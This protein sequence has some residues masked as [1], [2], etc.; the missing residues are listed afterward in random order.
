MKLLAWPERLEIRHRF[1]QATWMHTGHAHVG[2]EVDVE[3]GEV[4]PG[5][6]TGAEP[7]AGVGAAEPESG[8]GAADPEAAEV[9]AAELETETEPG[10]DVGVEPG[11]GAGAAGPGAAGVGAAETGSGV[12]VEPG[13]G[14][15]PE[16]DGV[17]PE[18]GVG[19][20]PETTR[21]VAL[22]F[23]EPN[24]ND[25]ACSVSKI[26]VRGEPLK[27]CPDQPVQTV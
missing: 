26:C 8:A 5:V 15:E 16:I 14:T 7:G 17:E 4:E 22:S 20:E 19:V 9:G 1:F 10:I 25:Q 18:A 6:D 3:A 24:Q 2:V 23:L 11:V 21:I 27:V 13:A 12:G